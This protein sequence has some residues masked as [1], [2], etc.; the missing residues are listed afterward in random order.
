MLVVSISYV[1]KGEKQGKNQTPVFHL[2]DRWGEG[3]L[4]LKKKSRTKVQLCG[5]YLSGFTEGI[6]QNHLIFFT[7]AAGW[8]IVKNSAKNASA[9]VS[10]VFSICT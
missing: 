5:N 6:D 4:P 7:H 8:N 10:W 9:E 3:K 1:K 2:G